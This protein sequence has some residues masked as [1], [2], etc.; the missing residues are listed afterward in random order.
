MNEESLFV[1]ALEIGDP[2]ARRAFLERACTGDVALRRRVEQL[3]SA[4]EKTLGILDQSEIPAGSSSADAGSGADE[5]KREIRTGAVLADRYKLL[6][7]I[8]VGGMGTVW[9]AEQTQPVRRTV[10]LKL[11]RAGMATRTVLSRFEAERQA[12]AVMD[13]PNIAKVL[14][15]GATESGRPFFVMEYVKGVPLTQYCDEARLSI[16]QR[17]A[18]FVPICQ[19][20]Q[21][22]HTKG[23]IHRDLKPNNILVCLYDGEPVPK[24]IDFGLAK[25]I[26][27]PLTEKTLHTAHGALLGTPLYMSPEQAELNNL[28]VD[29]RADVYALGV[30]LYE[31]L[32]GTTP[33]ERARFQAAAWHELLRLIK[34][35]E[36]PRPSSRLSNSDSLPSLAA[37]RR[38]EP[39]RLTRLVRGELDWIVMKCLEK[40]RARRYDTAD[41][42]AR[43]VQRYLTDESVEAC[44]PSARYRLSK[45]VRRHR[46]PVWAGSIIALLLVAG[47]FGTSWGLVRANRAS[48]DAQR[49]LRQLERGIDFLES[50]FKDLDPRA[51]EKEGRPLRAILG[52]RIAEA[53]DQ[54]EGEGFG[55]PLLTADLQYR[56]GQTLLHLGMP[57]RA[58]PLFEKSRAT[59][60]KLLGVIHRDSL[61]SMAALAEGYGDIGDDKALPLMEENLR[62]R[63]ANL[64]AD[65]SHTL[66]SMNA[67]AA[68]HK[69]HGNFALAVS[70]LEETFKLRKA[71]QGFDHPD[72]LNCM[73][74]LAVSYLAAKRLDLALPLYK[75]T[76][77]LRQA[78]LGPNHTET[79]NSMNGLAEAYR[80]A[81]KLD[82]ALPLFEQTL[83]LRKTRLGPD[84]P[85]TLISM[86]NLAA[87]HKD[88]QKLELALP[89]LEET[90][91]LSKAR[92]GP[93][94]LYTLGSMSNLA[95][96]YRA[97]GK[98]N[99]AARVFLEAAT[100]IEK[101]GFRDEFAGGIIT[102]LVA[103][104]EQMLQFAEA[105]SWRRKWLGVVKAKAGA[106]SGAYAG[107]LGKLGANLIE[108]KKWTEAELAEREALSILEKT[109]ST[110]VAKFIVLSELGTALL[111]QRKFAD[112]EPMLVQ[113]YEGLKAREGQ[114]APPDRRRVVER[115]EQVVRLYEIWGQPEKAAEWRTR[116]AV[117]AGDKPPA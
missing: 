13:H 90:V 44:P 77:E 58:I 111:G 70:L 25:A 88:N 30:I 17:L 5:A 32:T 46:G 21:H 71:K 64:G 103:T 109:A 76:L 33:L 45:F 68:I 72:T 34:E 105:E 92:R 79:L 61:S 7:S 54:I 35:E 50:V 116:L 73:N 51:E 10:A 8:G 101:R 52:Q 63:K 66:F 18:L 89:L 112:A 115:G 28:D 87:A 1:A 20:V 85:D 60:V 27:E 97:M 42:L 37:Q 114:M 48:K 59:R 53:A 16:A 41:G 75:Q 93:D 94:N 113:G 24:V 39:V 91:R 117:A 15:G 106:D 67:L 98:T 2:F 11:I 108:Q 29:A 47:I 26:Q 83:A 80:L 14:D 107:E 22:A 102:H 110:S 31:L 95:W 100:T 6:E 4:H 99:E 19:A 81:G 9:K 74:N 23:V 38:L 84:D 56:T 104:L 40:D 3:L 57:R 69:S 65:D 78:K 49:R 82:K 96:T 55:D 62:L 86:N 43:D 12:L 36:P